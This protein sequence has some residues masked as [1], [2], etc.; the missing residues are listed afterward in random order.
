MEARHTTMADGQQKPFHRFASAPAMLAA[1]HDDPEPPRVKVK[2]KHGTRH[3]MAVRFD[4]KAHPGQ[5]RAVRAAKP[6]LS[7]PNRY[8]QDKAKRSHRRDSEAIHTGHT[9][10]L[11]TPRLSAIMIK[12]K[13]H[14]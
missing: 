8:L 2:T 14:E 7:K 3:T 11:Q 6:R 1:T 9:S 4:H 5:R 12:E 10:P 13:C